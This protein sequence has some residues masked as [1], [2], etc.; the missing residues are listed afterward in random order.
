[1]MLV[2][3][4]YVLEPYYTMYSVLFFYYLVGILICSMK[5]LFFAPKKKKNEIVLPYLSFVEDA[6][7]CEIVTGTF[8][9]G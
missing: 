7:S 6:S 9:Y 1:M 4:Y 8:S 3:L 5:L 2:T